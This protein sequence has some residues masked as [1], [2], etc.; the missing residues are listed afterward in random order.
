M[1]EVLFGKHVIKE[2]LLSNY[3]LKKI[4]TSSTAAELED[5]YKLA[6][7]KGIL[8]ERVPKEKLDDLAGKRHQGIV[9]LASH[10][11]YVELD[12]ILEEIKRRKDL[13]F[14]L[15]LDHLKDPQNVGNILRTA[16][17]G[18]IQGII[19]PKKRSVGIT[20]TVFKASAGAAF[21]LPI[22]Q[23]NNI[24]QTLEKLKREGIWIIGASPDASAFCYETD[25]KLPLA[26]VLGEE[27]KGLNRLV[28]E[29]CDFLVKIPMMGKIAS[30]NVAAAASIL[31]YEAFRQRKIDKGEY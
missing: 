4:M 11:R 2:A 29:K 18:G 6:H 22:A 24:A 8:I 30:L 20:S 3:P 25:F 23:V 21:Y 7:Q 15:V 16:E 17:T 12:N 27:G 10:P 26:L 1:E 9:A 13:P 31:I 19:I 28:K 5:F 14:L